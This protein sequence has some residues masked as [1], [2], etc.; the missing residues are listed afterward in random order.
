[1]DEKVREKCKKTVYPNEMWGSFHGHQCRRNV[2]KD[3]YCKT[4]HSDTVKARAKE[5]EKLWQEKYKG[6]PILLLQE[7]NTRIKE[8]EEAIKKHKNGC[9]VIT[10]FDMIDKN[11]ELYKVLK[12]S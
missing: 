11:K 8:L 7:A 5:H 9:D 4:H 2:W 6:N 12:E 10:E 3:G 1:M